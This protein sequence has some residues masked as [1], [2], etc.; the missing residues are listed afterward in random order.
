MITDTAI[1]TD[2]VI[3][4]Q[5]HV[6]GEVLKVAIWIDVVIQL[7]IAKQLVDACGGLEIYE[8]QIC[9]HGLTVQGSGS[10]LARTLE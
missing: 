4:R 2:T 5:R 6:Q 8:W 3:K 1:K 7:E 10:R 9:L